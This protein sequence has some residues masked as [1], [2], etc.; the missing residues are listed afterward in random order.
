[1]LGFNGQREDR[2]SGT[3]LLGNGY[4][5][6]SPVL[7]RFQAPD[8]LSPFGKGGLNSY[9]YCTGDPVNYLDESGH[10][11]TAAQSQFRMKQMGLKMPSAA[12]GKHPSAT[13]PAS[14]ALQVPLADTGSAKPKRSITFSETT[15]IHYYPKE[16]LVLK[17][18]LYLERKSLTSHMAQ[19]Y[20]RLE[21][22]QQGLNVLLRPATEAMFK[23]HNSSSRQLS[24]IKD[25]Q[26]Q[27][28]DIHERLRH[29]GKTLESIRL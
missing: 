27:I 25:Y 29:L 19:D 6:Y 23:A 20:R 15:K 16:S 12:S 13:R 21:I 9:A 3:Y 24:L 22:Y 4:R 18:A 11:Q 14:R 2:Y 5:A 26:T 10:A 8:N 28:D 1:M 7:S 17:R